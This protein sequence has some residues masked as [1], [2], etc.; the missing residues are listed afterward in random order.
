MPRALF[1]SAAHL[2]RMC[3]KS[4]VRGFSRSLLSERKQRGESI[5][6]GPKKNSG[7]VEQAYRKVPFFVFWARQ[8]IR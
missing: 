7:K 3:V 6:A 4:G 2:A 8:F 1:P 5:S